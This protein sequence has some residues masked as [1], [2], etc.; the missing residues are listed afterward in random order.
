MKEQLLKEAQALEVSVELDGIFESANLTTEQQSKFATVFEQAVKVQA[1]ALAESHITAIAA[2][3]EAKIEESVEAKR[4]EIET[5]LVEAANA[6]AE[7]TAAD[8]LEANQ[9][10]IDRGIKAD[11]FESMFGGLKALVVEHNVVLPEESVDV[12]AE[13]E[14]E[15]EVAK[16]ETSKLFNT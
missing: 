1:A 13:L 7:H 8:W 9:V 12:V 11:L 16:V 14:G 2:S 5:H 15:V 4:T 3:A 10:A 6:L